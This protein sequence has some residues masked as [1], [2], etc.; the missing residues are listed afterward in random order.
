MPPPPFPNPATTTESAH[1]T[2]VM[3][4]YFDGGEV[5]A[6]QV[7]DAEGGEAVQAVD[8]PDVVVG[9]IEDAQIRQIVK[10]LR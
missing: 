4:P 10:T 3:A 5:V 2:S 9:K 6:G 7:E 1:K 8:A